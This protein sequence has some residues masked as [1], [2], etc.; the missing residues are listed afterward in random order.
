MY[1]M[2][3]PNR[4][5]VFTII[6]CLVVISAS[7]IY[8]YRDS[9]F[10]NTGD[11]GVAL[12][13]STNTTPT[14]NSIETN[15]DWA[16]TV[17]QVTSE[18]ASSISTTTLNSTEKFSRDFFTTYA[19]LYNSDQVNNVELVNAVTEKLAD[20]SLET[21]NKSKIYKI[22]DLKINNS[23]DITTLKNYYTKLKLVTDGI[24]SDP[25]ELQIV[26][27]ALEQDDFKSLSYLDAINKRYNENINK[28]LLIEVPMAISEY[29]L[30]MINSISRQIEN[31]NLFINLED[32]PLPALNAL[33]DSIV[34]FNDVYYANQEI[35]SYMKL[36]GMAI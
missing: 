27:M 10:K 22:T 21:E 20:I 6:I 25:N 29:H 32:N 15:D 9:M 18:N 4:Q 3:L 24:W 31:V 11:M 19:T 26:S 36:R 35:E 12:D 14:R 5:V 13:V 30:S 33:N 28:L 23:S 34:N 8:A 2:T 17:N 7:A 1:Q 16:K